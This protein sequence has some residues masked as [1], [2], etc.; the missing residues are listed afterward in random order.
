MTT[1]TSKLVVL[2]LLFIAKC[3][4]AIGETSEISITG[5]D[6]DS[7]LHTSAKSLTAAN[8]WL[9]NFI[10]WEA[11]PIEYQAKESN[12][13]RI[14]FWARG[15]PDGVRM[16]YVVFFSLDFDTNRKVIC[17]PGE[18]NRWYWLNMS[19]IYRGESDGRCFYAEDKWG[20]SVA[21][22]LA[23]NN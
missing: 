5:P 6:L 17:L 9:G 10:N 23:D 3:A 2:T 7:P 1:T 22:T 13:Y 16:I 8:V 20:N 11:G 21:N 15:V 18:S 4:L 12:M 14:H 19:T